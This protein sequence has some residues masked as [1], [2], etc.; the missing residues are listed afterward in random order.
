M[1]KRWTFA[2]WA[3]LRCPACN[4]DS[5][6]AGWFRT[7]KRCSACGQVFERESGF[8]AGAIY[9]FYAASAGLGGLAVLLGVLAFDLPL[10]KALIPAA[11]LVAVLSP[12]L[13]WYARLFFLHTDH[14]F[15]REDA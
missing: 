7:A 1:S 12:W 4:A 14:R 6:R 13:F 5:F 9:P 3:A 2:S 10:E 11:L 15:F 8:F